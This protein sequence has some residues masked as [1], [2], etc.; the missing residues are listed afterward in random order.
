MSMGPTKKR[1]ITLQLLYSFEFETHPDDDQIHFIMR[2]LHISK[3]HAKDAQQ[4][5]HKIYS[6]QK[7]LDAYIQK[8]SHSYAVDRIQ[9]VERNIL[10]LV[11]FELLFEK[12]L[13]K[14]IVIAEAKRLARKFATN[15]SASFIHS[16]L[17]HIIENEAVDAS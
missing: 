17:D 2:E 14:K 3:Q 12:S 15:D 13:S 6:K 16:L 1:E 8:A 4:K 11:L 5:A 10:R 7:E 9:S